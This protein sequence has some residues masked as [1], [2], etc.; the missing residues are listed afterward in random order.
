LAAL[1]DTSVVI[2]AERGELDL[3]RLRESHGETGLVLAAITASELLHGVH[4]VR[5]AGRMA[6]AEAFVEA[7]LARIPV[8]PFD[9]ACARAHARIGAALARRGVGVGA[10]DLLIGATALTHGC[11]ILTRDRR[12]FQKIPDLVVQVL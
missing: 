4:R 5:G 3:D 8:V 6:R 11:S 7:I 10:H 2:A 1:V 12:G 9:L